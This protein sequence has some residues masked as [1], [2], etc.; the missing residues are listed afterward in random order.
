MSGRAERLPFRG[1]VVPEDDELP[2]VL[3]LTEPIIIP[4]VV[5]TGVRVTVKGGM[6]LTECWEDMELGGRNE[7]R[8]VGRGAFTT[9]TAYQLIDEL[10]R[11]LPPR[12]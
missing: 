2:E 11:K 10:L 1:L 8:L 3:E 9:E 7:R 12:H 5:L 4:R 6:V